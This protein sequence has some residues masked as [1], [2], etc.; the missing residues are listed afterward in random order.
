MEAQ[1]D[2]IV[3]AY[4]PDRELLA[5]V[6]NEML[7][8]ESHEHKFMR[9]RWE[10]ALGASR[11]ALDALREIWPAYRHRLS[12]Q[13]GREVKSALEHAEALLLRLN[14][15]DAVMLGEDVI[16]V[17]RGEITTVSDLEDYGGL[18]ALAREALAAI[19]EHPGRVART[20]GTQ[21]SRDLQELL[22]AGLVEWREDAF[23]PTPAGMD[24]FPG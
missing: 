17:L 22:D 12:D 15:L 18:S 24:A 5:R 13:E 14:D 7:A 8:R 3:H 21:L 4:R 23:F 1:P 2:D 19:C 9:Q 11:V 6:T 16:G 10:H 20:L